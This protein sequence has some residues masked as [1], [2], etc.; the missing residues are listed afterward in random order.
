MFEVRHAEVVEH[1]KGNK[2]PQV[3]MFKCQSADCGATA[4]L[5]FEPIGG[6]APEDASWVEREIARR[7]SFFP[8]DYTGG[9][10]FR[11]R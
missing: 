11:G 8:S 6:T 1:P 3:E 9:G 5:M 7:G 10:G 2:G 4:A